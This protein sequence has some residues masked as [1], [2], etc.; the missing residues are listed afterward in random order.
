MENAP[1]I[2]KQTLIWHNMESQINWVYDDEHYPSSKSYLATLDGRYVIGYFEKS[3]Q[4]GRIFFHTDGPTV[5][6][7]D[8]SEFAE[9]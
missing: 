1:N 8:L 5:S 9:L 3:K 2:R 6:L 4:T 7:S